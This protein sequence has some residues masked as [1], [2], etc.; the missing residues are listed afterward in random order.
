MAK[1]KKCLILSLFFAAM[2]FAGVAEAGPW[3][4]VS[5]WK[6]FRN[7]EQAENLKRCNAQAGSDKKCSTNLWEH[8]NG[9]FDVCLL[10][11]N[12]PLKAV[13]TFKGFSQAEQNKNLALCKKQESQGQLCITSLWAHGQAAYDVVL[14][15]PQEPEVKKSA[16][17]VNAGGDDDDQ[18]PLGAAVGAE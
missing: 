9:A 6:G 8:E 11:P 15:A 1:V 10:E 14:M 18:E 16:V 17:K 12:G 5:C 4:T 13:T 3:K 2:S 7:S